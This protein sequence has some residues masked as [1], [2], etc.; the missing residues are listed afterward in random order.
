MR[1]GGGEAGCPAGSRC[2]GG[3]TS[4]SGPG[5][6]AAGAGRALGGRSGESVPWT[7]RPV[8]RACR[9]GARPQGW[10]WRKPWA[11]RPR[12]GRSSA[13]DPSPS[14]LPASCGLV[15]L[16]PR[17]A[18]RV[19]GSSGRDSSPGSPRI[20]G[21]RTPPLTPPPPPC[22]PPPPRTPRAA[23]HGAHPRLGWMQGGEGRGFRE[24]G[25]LEWQVCSPDPEVAF[26]PAPPHP[27]RPPAPGTRPGFAAPPGPPR[28]ARP[29][30]RDSP[31]PRRVS[32][33][34]G[35][36]S[37]CGGRRVAFPGEKALLGVGPGVRHVQTCCWGAAHLILEVAGTGGWRGADI[38]DQSHL[39]TESGPGCRWR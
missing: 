6:G 37:V 26:S 11:L 7:A 13:P 29:K 10:W 20:F 14:P 16:G 17:G 9:F 18:L 39:G 19:E 32:W 22:A 2:P 27:P 28:A 8:P 12:P 4:A 3:P 23:P 1:A 5:W 15:A 33:T 31:L 35:Q 21:P 36:S 38:S 24:L 25:S 34:W 30:V